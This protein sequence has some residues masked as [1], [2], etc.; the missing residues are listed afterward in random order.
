MKYEMLDDFSNSKNGFFTSESTIHKQ[1]VI[2]KK[3]A[4]LKKRISELEDIFM[5]KEVTPKNKVKKGYIIVDESSDDKTIKKAKNRQI[6]NNFSSNNAKKE[7]LNQLKQSCQQFSD[8]IEFF[9]D[10]PEQ[11]KVIVQINI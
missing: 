8:D 3:I 9:S 1:K 10:D 11:I 6:I 5:V 7:L 4:K 2:L